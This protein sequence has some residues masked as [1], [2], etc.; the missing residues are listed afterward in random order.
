M[1]KCAF[2]GSTIL[3]GGKSSNNRSF[4]NERCA[5]RGLLLSIADTIPQPQ[6]EQQV[7]AVHQGR[8]PKCTGP[9]PIDVHVSHRVWS[10]LVL[11]SWRSQPRISC[12]SCGTKAQLGDA[13]FS[14]VCGWWGFPWGVLLTP[15]QIG[16]D[17][18]GMVKGPEPTK[19][20][21]SLANMVRMQMAANAVTAR[22]ADPQTAKTQRETVGAPR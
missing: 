21:A 6:V 15:I 10:V 5:Q 12:R 19:P 18:A 13:A 11:T 7:W 17:V 4:C 22:A 3:F 8:C 1:T 9:G 2:C 16:R 20:S 14:L